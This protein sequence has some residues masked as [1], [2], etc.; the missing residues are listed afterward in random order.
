MIVTENRLNVIESRLEATGLTKKDLERSLA[1]AGFPVSYETIMNWIRKDYLPFP[2]SDVARTE[3]LA[4][5]LGLSPAQLLAAYGHNVTQPNDS[6]IPVQLR[7][8]LD[9]YNALPQWEREK[10]TKIIYDFREMWEIMKTVK[11]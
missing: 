11:S 8:F 2:V 10:F 7:S 5:I 1:R 4:R 3:A 9:W 6:T